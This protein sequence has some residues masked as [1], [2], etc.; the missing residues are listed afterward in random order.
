LSQPDENAPERP[1]GRVSS[2]WRGIIGAFVGV[3]CIAFLGRTLWHERLEIRSAL[4]LGPSTLLLLLGLAFLAHLQRT[5][6]FNFMLR[7]LGV[8][9]RYRDGFVL[10]GTVA[11]LN[12]IPFSTGSVA[13]G[14]ALRHRYTLAYATYVSALMISSVM[15]GHVAADAGLV[16]SLA[17]TLD[18]HHG[19]LLVGL[20]AL[21]S[22]ASAV[23]LLLPLAWIPRG[24]G[25]IPRQIHRITDGLR[26]LRR[27]SGLPVLA[28]V[29]TGK[30]TSSALRV[31]LCLAALGQKASLAD[32]ILLGSA[33][34]ILSLVSIVPNNIGLRELVLGA[35]AGLIGFSPGLGA[36]AATL[37]RAVVLGYAVIS[38]LPC[39]Y[40][41]RR[42]MR[43]AEQA[44]PKPA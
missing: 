29:S 8:P 40:L 28:L 24:S 26:V 42:S 27:G 6:E 22:C 31:W 23:A 38:G 20:F 12:Y 3:G 36:A 7:R 10:T 37:D 4:D 34:V 17:D 13:R 33:S 1:G 19:T 18:T 39:L 11:L 41:M 5:F 14:V 25:F 2:R 44:S 32:V 16:I 15:N 30:I 43:A 35:L 21:V 9:E